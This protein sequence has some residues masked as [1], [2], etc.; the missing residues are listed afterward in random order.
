MS[1]IS[2]YADILIMAP[3]YLGYLWAVDKF[4]KKFLSTS[5]ARE[6]LFVFFPF[7]DGCF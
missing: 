5:K 3:C 7:V 1:R 6:L 4:C 2:D